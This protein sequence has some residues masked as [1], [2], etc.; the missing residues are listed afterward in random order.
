MSAQSEQQEL[1]QAVAGWLSY[2]SLT[3][4]RGHLNEASISVPITEFLST[5]HGESMR[6][7]V[8]HPLFKGEKRKGRPK[9]LDFVQRR[10]KG[11][12][13]SWLAAYECKFQTDLPSRMIADICRLLVLNQAN[14]I[15]NPKRFFLLAG[16]RKD[17]NIPLDR[18]INS[19][20]SGRISV[21]KD[22]LLRQ[23]SEINSQLSVRL[24]TLHAEQRSLYASFAREND[25][26]IP[27]AFSTKLKGLSVAA[28]YSCAIWEIK[29]AN[30][31][32][33]LDASDIEN[34]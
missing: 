17:P 23:P 5:R 32:K 30:G 16:E 3:G 29:A 24:N 20:A 6:S 28:K 26:K 31:S 4:L 13:T 11:E 8:A 12:G 1:T 9:Q 27:S 2:K 25:V 15:G 33:L 10:R 19:T 14:G 34:A 18:M 22:T 7:E 21:F